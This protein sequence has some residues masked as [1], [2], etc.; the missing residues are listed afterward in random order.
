MKVWD[1]VMSLSVADPSELN[2]LLRSILDEKT[3]KG[4][5]ACVYV[6]VYRELEANQII[7][8]Y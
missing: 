2:L 6:F 7:I 3:L 5:T 1:L 8:Q 4:R